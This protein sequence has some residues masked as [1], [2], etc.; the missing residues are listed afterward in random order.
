MQM[1][2]TTQALLE[3]NNKLE[4]LLSSV[5]MLAQSQANMSEDITKIK[6]AV[7]NPD[8][9]LYARIRALELWKESTSKVQWII[10]SAMVMLVAKQF[11]EF[12]IIQ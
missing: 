4:R 10:I 3:L 9:G 1:D 7:Y 5:E 12:V 8:E 2:E 6:E 11:W